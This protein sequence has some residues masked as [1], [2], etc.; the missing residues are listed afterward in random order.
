[1]VIGV[2][3]EYNPFHNGHI[4]HI[5]KIKEK[6]PNSIIVAVM[7][8]N[9]TERGDLSIIDKWNKTKIAL[10]YDIDLVIELPF[11]FASQSADLFAKG[12]IEILNEM[13]VDKIIFGSECNDINILT[14]LANIQLS[15]EYNNLVKDYLDK[16]NYPTALSL[17]LKKTSNIEIKNPNDIL[18]MC[19]IKEIIKN[20]YNIEVESI[21]R[22][23]DY[24]SKKLEVIASA[25]SI[26][27]AIKNNINI[28]K[29]VPK[30]TIK[31]I[32]TNLDL[33]NFFELIKYKI[34]SI[35][36]LTYIHG[37]DEKIAPRLK[38]EILKSNSLEELIQ[39]IKVKKYSYNRIKRLLIYILFDYTKKEHNTINYIRI[40]GFNKKGQDYLSKIKKDIKL[41]I[42]TNYSNSNHLI[43][44]DI[45]IKNIISLVT[46]E[47][48]NKEKNEVIIK[49]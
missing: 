7:S 6:Y 25:T 20:N 47:K 19:Y 1:M 21:K 35:D 33:N 34:L 10:K 44:F 9:V 43:D 15:K 8:G 11:K 30:E 22:T 16:Y 12:A 42:I 39:N 46:K 38:K 2:I 5:N 3:V 27:E 4:Y 24:N 36:D 41:N 26:R 31:Y 49:K 45:K 17:A 32:N 13:K 18:G 37:I 28:S 23:N 29:Y 48:L 40:L 14:K